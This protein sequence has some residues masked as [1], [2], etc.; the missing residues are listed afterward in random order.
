VLAVFDS[1]DEEI[2][3]EIVSEIIP[4]V[5]EPSWYLVRVKDGIVT[6]EGTPETISTSAEVLARI[7]HVQGVVAVRDRLPGFTPSPPGPWSSP[8]PPNGTVARTRR[9]RRW[10]VNDHQGHVR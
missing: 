2:R 1:R 8:W 6:V 3:E 7:R 5:S 9:E 10:R 4:G